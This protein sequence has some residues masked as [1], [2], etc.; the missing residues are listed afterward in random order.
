MKPYYFKT[1]ITTI[2]S[3]KNRRSKVNCLLRLNNLKY[4]KNYLEKYYFDKIIFIVLAK[5]FESLCAEILQK[6]IP[7][8]S[9]LA[10]KSTV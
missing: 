8:G 3:K 10:L 9:S 2:S 7:L 1:K 5:S 6:Y 4:K